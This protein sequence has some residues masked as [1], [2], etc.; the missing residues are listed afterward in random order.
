[1]IKMKRHNGGLKMDEFKSNLAS[2]LK[3]SA[4]DVEAILQHPNVQKE[5]ARSN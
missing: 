5:L 3:V 4:Q 1:M 2:S